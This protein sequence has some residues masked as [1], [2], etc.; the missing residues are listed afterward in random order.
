MFLMFQHCAVVDAGTGA[1]LWISRGLNA[2]SFCTHDVAVLSM[3]C[4]LVFG[5]SSTTA[6]F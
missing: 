4:V 1:A 2:S 6:A 5:L 3:S